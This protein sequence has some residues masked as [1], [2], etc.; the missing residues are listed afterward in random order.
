MRKIGVLAT[1]LTLLVGLNFAYA[2]EDVIELGGLTSKIPAT[3][4]MQKPSN[5]L[6][7]Y[8][9][10]VPRV[11]GDKEDAELAVF[12]FGAS[13]KEE[14]VKRWKAQFIAPDGKTLDDVTKMEDYKV[15][16]VADVFCLDISG[17][18][19][20][21]NPPQ[22]PTAKEE[23]KE[24]FRRFNVMFDTDKGLFFITL[25]GPA[26]TMEKNK[27]AFDGWLKAFK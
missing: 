9:V 25:T 8:Q 22:S 14:N 7:K 15:G 20:Y 16:K 6:R 18:F 3:W 23:R 13:G 12:S 1:S 5:N 27:A 17:T 2:G 11:E 19:K 24:N 26:K 10:L 21:K 4:K